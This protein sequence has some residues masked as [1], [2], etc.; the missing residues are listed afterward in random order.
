[1]G[2]MDPSCPSW[3]PAAPQVKYLLA[4]LS[5]LLLCVMADFLVLSHALGMR[6]DG[7]LYAAIHKQQLMSIRLAGFS[8]KNLMIC[9]VLGCAMV[10]QPNN[11]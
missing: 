11:T 10:L 6:S 3:T 5:H 1:M 4:H 7:N 2:L 9:T 8:C